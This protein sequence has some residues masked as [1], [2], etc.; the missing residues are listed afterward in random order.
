MCMYTQ[1]AHLITEIRVCADFI[2][3][4]A[5]S[6]LGGSSFGVG[7]SGPTIPDPKLVGFASSLNKVFKSSKKNTRD[8]KPNAEDFRV[9]LKEEP[10][11][12][13]Y[14]G[15]GGAPRRGAGSP[16]SDKKRVLNYWCFSPGVAMED[17]K[18]LGVRSLILTSGT[19]SPMDAFK[20]DMKVPFSVELENPHVIDRNQIWISALASGPSGAQLLSTYERRDT[21]EYKDELGKSILIIC[22][23]ML[24]GIMNDGKA[25]PRL[26]GGVLVFFPSYGTMETASSRWKESGLWAQLTQVMGKVVAETQS[27]KSN[28]TNKSHVSNSY[29]PYDRNEKWTAGGAKQSHWKSAGTKQPAGQNRNRDTDKD[30]DKD[31]VAGIIQDFEGA[32]ALHG[33][34]LLLAV[35]RGKVS[36]GIDFK[37]NK[38]RVAIMTGIPFSPF[39]DPW[40]VLKKQYLDDNRKQKGLFFS[41]T[42]SSSAPAVKPAANKPAQYKPPMQYQPSSSAQYKPSSLILSGTMQTIKS[43][44]SGQPAPQSSS[45][46]AVAQSSSGRQGGSQRLSGQAWYVQSASRAVN[47]ALGRVIRHKHDWGA[48]FLLDSRY[49]RADQQQQLSGWIR[50]RVSK[51]S[52]FSGALQAFR[53]FCT[54]ALQN[55]ALAVKSEVKED[56]VKNYRK[57]F[58]PPTLNSNN[59]HG[60]QKSLIVHAS[61]LNGGDE[62]IQYIN[63][64]LAMSQNSF[65]STADSKK[66]KQGFSLST[67]ANPSASQQRGVHEPSQSNSN[68]VSKMFSMIKKSNSNPV[69][70][71]AKLRPGDKIRHNLQ[72]QSTLAPFKSPLDSSSNPH[73]ENVLAQKSRIAPGALLG[74]G[75]GSSSRDPPA[76]G[77]LLGQSTG[78]SRRLTQS[79]DFTSASRRGGGLGRQDAFTSSSSSSCSE[80]Q[81]HT[82]LH[83]QS[84]SQS[85]SSGAFFNVSTVQAAAEAVAKKRR[86]EGKIRFKALIGT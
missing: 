32:L 52:D 27:K 3:D 54:A 70:T 76:R 56:V 53:C 5:N 78:S 21:N 45:T 84:Q 71:S 22:Q 19:L 62:D 64:S 61:A 11:N 34:C 30:T 43:G 37:D 47:Q 59:Q 26:N 85:Q 80:S 6:M 73:R 49:Q 2:M 63:P 65:D 17:L 7:G 12:D 39:M 10:K 14:S 67:T 33:K 74:S 86:A 81:S 9:F 1:A 8:N 25:H 55:K 40:V 48:V 24:G 50:P 44:G 46:S 83:S 4:D 41:S 72:T 51:Y 13:Y 75:S 28:W 16:G 60:F 23:N 77:L 38:G 42:P 29:V 79:D 69:P 82:Q 57:P 36:E 15:G 68:D 35:C 66:G 31:V 18:A 58:V 20:E